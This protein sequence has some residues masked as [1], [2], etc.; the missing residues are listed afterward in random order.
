MR[1]TND[2]DIV[3][4]IETSRGAASETATA[5]GSLGYDLRSVVDLR[6]DTA[7]RFYRGTSKIDL[8]ANRPDEEPEEV[9]DVLISD[10]HA[11][12][13]SGSPDATWSASH[14][15]QDGPG[16]PHRR[17]LTPDRADAGISGGQAAL[18]T[19]HGHAADD[20]APAASGSVAIGAFR[21]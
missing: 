20:H 9:V 13:V 6:D 11:P 4:H 21:K 10:H 14:R 2:V 17:G 3:L 1:P 18:W 5:L 12:K 16:D 19:E 15:R 7:H 8:V